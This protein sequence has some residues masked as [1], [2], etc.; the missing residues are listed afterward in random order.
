MGSSKRFSSLDPKWQED[1]ADGLD[2]Q[3]FIRLF[4]EN[5]RRIYGFILSILPNPADAEDMLQETSL[6]LWR[7]FGQF[8]IGT[9]FV[10][11]ACRVAQFEVLKFYE[12]RAQ[13]GFR[14]DMQVLEAVAD[15]AMEMSSVLEERYHAS[16]KCIESLSPRDQDLLQRRYA[17]GS[18]PQQIAPQVGRSIDAVYKALSRIHDGLMNCI[19][20]RIEKE[21]RE[22]G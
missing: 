13:L 2:P 6:I 20:W 4:V 14:F 17:N 3:Q 16:G 22:R 19:R 12:R 7:K 5:E 18:T 11:W 15:D 9:D 1:D 8:S 10:A 21:N